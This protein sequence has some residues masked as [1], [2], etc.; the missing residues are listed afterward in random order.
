MSLPS[1]E[2]RG[3]DSSPRGEESRTARPPVLGATHTSPAYTKAIWVADTAR[4]SSVGAAWW[5][6]G[7]VGGSGE[8]T[9]GASRRPSAKPPGN[10]DDG[11]TGRVCAPAGR[12]STGGM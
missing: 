8:H 3:K 9:Q 2:K 6:A 12:V 11:R 10:G 7:G 4:W 5:R 1:G